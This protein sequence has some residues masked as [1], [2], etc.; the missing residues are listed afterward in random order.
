VTYG[1]KTWQSKKASAPI[2]DLVNAARNSS[3]PLHDQKRQK[4]LLFAPPVLSCGTDGFVRAVV[5]IS[6]PELPV[7]KLLI[8]WLS[9]AIRAA[10]K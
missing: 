5:N 1:G 4:P 8:D 10:N 9:S 7:S 3:I 6:Q 2:Q